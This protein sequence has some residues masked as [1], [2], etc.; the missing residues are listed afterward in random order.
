M[1]VITVISLQESDIE[2]M[3][4][5]AKLV[6]KHIEAEIRAGIPSN[7]VILG[8]FSQGNPVVDDV[9]GDDLDPVQEQR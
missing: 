7:K 5:S 2:G 3:K 6:F 4:Q 9:H 1:T 8:G